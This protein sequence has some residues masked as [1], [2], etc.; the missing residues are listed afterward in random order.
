MNTKSFAIGFAA[1]DSIIAGVSATKRGI[2]HA[3]KSTAHGA[4]VSAQATKTGALN[5]SEAVT[6]FF[7]GAKQA[8]NC[9]RGTCRMLTL[10]VRSNEE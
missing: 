5:T 7:A 1:M 3:A 9:R 2:V 4:Q 6:S 10:D 8:V